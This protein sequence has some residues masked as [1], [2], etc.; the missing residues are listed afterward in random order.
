GRAGK[1]E[2]ISFVFNAAGHRGR[3][4]PGCLAE[5]H[6]LRTILQAD[7][8]DRGRSEAQQEEGCEGDR[9]VRFASSTQP[10]AEDGCD[11]RAFQEHCVEEDRWKSQGHAGLWFPP[12]CQTLF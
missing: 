7:Q 10:F 1:A 5:L 9:E 4:Y 8:S 11:R 3:F 12:A 6:Y 2:A